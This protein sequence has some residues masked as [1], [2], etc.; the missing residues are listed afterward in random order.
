MGLESVLFNC[1][2]CGAILEHVNESC[3]CINC[4][5]TVKYATGDFAVATQGT[6]AFVIVEVHDE[7]SITL[8]PLEGTIRTMLGS[9]EAGVFLAFD[10]KGTHHANRTRSSS[11]R[12]SGEDS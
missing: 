10:T 5:K 2:N 6:K 3:Y 12:R 7:D 4:G 8:Y 1:P 11:E 9:K